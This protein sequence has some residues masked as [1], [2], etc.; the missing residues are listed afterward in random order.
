MHFLDSL[1]LELD[2]C[3]KHVVL[4]SKCDNLQ[5]QS[6]CDVSQLG[7]QSGYYSKWNPSNDWG[8][9]STYEPG[10]NTLWQLIERLINVKSMMTK[11]TD[12][13]AMLASLLKENDNNLSEEQRDCLK[14]LLP[15]VTVYIYCSPCTRLIHTA[16]RVCDKI[17][18]SLVKVAIRPD[19]RLLSSC[20]TASDRTLGLKSILE[21]VREWEVNSTAFET[22]IIAKSLDRIWLEQ[23]FNHIEYEQ[24]YEYKESQESHAIILGEVDCLAQLLQKAPGRIPKET[25]IW[26]FQTS[27][28]YPRSFTRQLFCSFTEKRRQIGIGIQQAVVP[29][30]SVPQL[31]RE[32]T[33]SKRTSSPASSEHKRQKTPAMPEDGDTESSSELGSPH[34]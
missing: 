14:A 3:R 16:L 27:N 2:L 24:P 32:V 30:V 8:I 10:G 25:E 18:S 33:K 6:P 21:H 17:T 26:A 12:E 11:I 7:S 13:E 23:R 9:S 34:N 29:G 19:D 20:C 4:T 1:I 15:L 22:S 5:A 28:S 31:R